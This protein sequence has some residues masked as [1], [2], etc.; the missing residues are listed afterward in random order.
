M[1]RKDEEHAAWK[2]HMEEIHR[3]RRELIESLVLYRLARR[4]VFIAAGTTPA[5]LTD[6]NCPF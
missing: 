4:G 2:A 3:T 5:V 6:E 1:R